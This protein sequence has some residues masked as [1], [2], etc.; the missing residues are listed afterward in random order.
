MAA[1]ESVSGRSQ[2]AFEFPLGIELTEGE[3]Y[4]QRQAYEVT[5]LK[6]DDV[7]RYQFTVAVSAAHVPELFARLGALLPERVRVV[8][9]IPGRTPSDEEVCEVYLSDAVERDEFLEA[10][11]AHDFLF[12]QDGMIGF[13]ALSEDERTELFLDDHKLLYFYSVDQEGP[14]RALASCGVPSCS[15]LRHFAELSHVHNSL[16]SRGRGEDYLDVFDEFKRAFNL[17]W[18]ET[19]EYE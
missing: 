16:A 1:E 14:E 11:A 13:G 15:R 4:Q 7:P 3:N 6:D 18:L 2:A 8:F 5:W 9:E 19:K 10:F 17:Q 12:S